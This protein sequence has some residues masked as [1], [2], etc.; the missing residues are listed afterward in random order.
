MDGGKRKKGMGG[1]EKMK[2][3]IW[4]KVEVRNR[5]GVRK[6]EEVW[7]HP[8]LWI[9][10][11]HLAYIKF[12][13]RVRFG[14][15]IVINFGMDS[16]TAQLWT[17]WKRADWLQHRSTPFSTTKKTNLKAFFE[18]SNAPRLMSSCVESSSNRKCELLI[19]PKTPL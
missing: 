2:G 7:S 10:C 4:R 9:S 14:K 16:T 3:S 17:A 13:I 12:A 11:V 18:R 6:E 8:I 1:A 19:F 5:I 15:S